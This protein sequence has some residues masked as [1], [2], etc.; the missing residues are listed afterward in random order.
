MEALRRAAVLTF[1][2]TIIVTTA[3][4]LPLM[5]GAAA[6]EREAKSKSTSTRRD[7]GGLAEAMAMVRKITV[8]GDHAVIT[9]RAAGDKRPR[10]LV[11]DYSEAANT[12]LYADDGLPI[13]WMMLAT[14]GIGL[15]MRLA[16]LSRINEARVPELARR[17][18][19][20]AD[21]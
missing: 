18:I 7:S 19:P 21:R 4:V 17:H 1:A 15:A 14:V 9:Y 10:G 20:P 12:L 11:V 8:A 2:A 16:R 13:Y 6:P 3:M 5:A